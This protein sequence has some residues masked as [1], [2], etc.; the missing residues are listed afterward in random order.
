MRGQKRETKCRRILKWLVG[1]AAVLHLGANAATLSLEG[2]AEG[3]Q[4]ILLPSRLTT[5]LTITAR[6]TGAS[7]TAEIAIA[8]ERQGVVVQRLTA[9]PPYTVALSNLS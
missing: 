5:N 8:L 4:I 3:A 1:F 6:P 2:I 9:S 7:P